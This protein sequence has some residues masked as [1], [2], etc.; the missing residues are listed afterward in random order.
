MR[1]DRIKVISEMAKKELKVPDVARR[2][3]VSVA[4]I[5]S[6]RRGISCTQETASAIAKALDVSLTDLLE[7]QR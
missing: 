6:I 4:T 3:G 5:S 7:N 1:L 2:A